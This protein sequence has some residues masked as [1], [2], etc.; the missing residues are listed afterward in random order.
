[1][2]CVSCH[3]NELLYLKM[4]NAALLGLITKLCGHSNNRL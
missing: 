4:R 2:V 1:V 3:V